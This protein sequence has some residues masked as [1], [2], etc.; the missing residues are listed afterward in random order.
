MGRISA[1]LL[2]GEFDA[3]VLQEAKRSTFVEIN[4][5]RR[6]Y[7]SFFLRLVASSVIA[8]AGIAENSTAAVIGAMLVAPLMSP[9]IGT[10]LAATLGLPRA[11]ARTFVQTA[12]GM[13]VA[14]ASAVAVCALIPVGVDLA[15]NPQVLSRVSPRLVDLVIALASGFIAA[16]ASLR[17]DIPDAVP[18]IAISASIVPPLCVVGAALYE[19]SLSAASGAFLLFVTNFVAILV[20]GAVVYV[21]MGLV[22]KGATSM[23]KGMR[24]AWY[25]ALAVGTVV[26]FALLLNT[27]MGVVREGVQTRLAQNIVAQW[28]S[29]STYRVSSFSFANGAVRVQVA[30][31]GDVPDAGRLM[32]ALEDVGVDVDELSVSHVDEVRVA[33]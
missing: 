9:M 12:L 18:G 13:A 5:A 21:L 17:S 26:V 30:G 20:A 27:S 28:A 6:Q 24:I 10:T 23:P 29:E 16:L 33:R 14:I 22:S 19:G 15:T 1:V 32:D 3:E 4:D 8:T 7:S 25:S 2:G 11:A 31:Q